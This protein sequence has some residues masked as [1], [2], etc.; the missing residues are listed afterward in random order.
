M[1][2]QL[3][4]LAFG[5]LNV[6]GF[7]FWFRNGCGLDQCFP[8]VIEVIKFPWWKFGSISP[9]FHGGNLTALRLICII[10]C[11]T[12]FSP[13]FWRENAAME[14]PHFHGKN[15]AEFRVWCTMTH[16]QGFVFVYWCECKMSY[17]YMLHIDTC[18]ILM[19]MQNVIFFSLNV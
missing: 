12:L 10:A 9:Y 2:K 18:C 1:K 13:K 17:W 5:A 3:L 14:M 11:Q 7:E 19:W 8:S 4:A 16:W 6:L 15:S